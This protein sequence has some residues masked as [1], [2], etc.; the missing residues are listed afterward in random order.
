MGTNLVRS[1][2][3][4][5]ERP[6]TSGVL[7]RVAELVD[8]FNADRYQQ[9]PPLSAELDTDV[10]RTPDG[11]AVIALLTDPAAV[12][13]LRFAQLH[14]KYRHATSFALDQTADS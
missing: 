1:E 11:A 5:L 8:Y 10:R 3:S 4:L 13:E 9:L 2:R 7:A 12:D 6:T 14:Q